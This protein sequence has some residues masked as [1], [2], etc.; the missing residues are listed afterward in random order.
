M[1]PDDLLLLTPT[2]LKAL[3]RSLA[4]KSIPVDLYMRLSQQQMDALP[5]FISIDE[6]P[7]MKLTPI[8]RTRSKNNKK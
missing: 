7:A 6:S 5:T 8:P 3:S 1:S 4:P 2:H